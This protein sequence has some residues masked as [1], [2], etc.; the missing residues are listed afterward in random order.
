MPTDN[1]TSPTVSRRTA[2]VLL[3]L[4]IL[5][6]GANWPVMKFG[7]RYIAPLSLVAAR[8]VLG[9]ITMFVFTGV[10]GNLRL[11]S[12]NDWPIVLGIGL[13][14]MTGFMALVTIALQVVP[15]G[16]S[17]ILAYTTSLWVVPGAVLVLGERLG[18]LKLTGFLLGLAG[19]GVM[20]NP[21]GFDWSDPHVVLGNGLLLLAAVL[22]AAL[23]VQIRY[24]RWEGSPLSLAPWQLGI[25]AIVLVPLAAIFDHGQPIR[26]SR[27]L[28]LVLLY[29]GLVTTAF[30]FWAITTVNRA[31]P[32][33]TTS[34]GTLGVPVTSVIFAAIF[35]GEKITLTNS[36]GLLLIGCGL[37]SVTLADRH[38]ARRG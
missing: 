8:V 15:P 22:W 19:V 28:D 21:F 18:P 29:N 6:W 38:G 33:I 36:L 27:N 13:M 2:T 3:V 32:A 31:L 11:P 20:F 17:S 34:L 30:C 35:L 1:A 14:Q 5:F 16:R 9:A 37:A 23:I 7:L 26:W 25:A 24:H 4:V 10:T 12:R